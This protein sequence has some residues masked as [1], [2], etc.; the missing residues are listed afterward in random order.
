[1]NP[2]PYVPTFIQQLPAFQPLPAG[3]PNASFTFYH[4]ALAA[5]VLFLFMK[6]V[7]GGVYWGLAL[8]AGVFLATP[9]AVQSFTNF[10]SFVQNPEG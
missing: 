1:M 5:L 10:L 2:S 9:G 3:N 7:P 6:Y 8:L 4:F